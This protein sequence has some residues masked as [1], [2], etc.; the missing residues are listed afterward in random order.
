MV[1]VEIEASVRGARG[2]IALSQIGERSDNGRPPKILKKM[3]SLFIIYKVFAAI[4]SFYLFI[5]I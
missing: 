5:V 4:D 3:F 1:A 2:V